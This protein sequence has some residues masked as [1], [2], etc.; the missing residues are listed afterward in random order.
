MRHP[1]NRFA[2]TDSRDLLPILARPLDEPI[3]NSLMIPTYLVS[4][5]VHEHCTEFALGK[6]PSRLNATANSRK[7]QAK[8]PR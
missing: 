2:D 1:R 5:L 8:L 6:L 3:V 4:R 7:V